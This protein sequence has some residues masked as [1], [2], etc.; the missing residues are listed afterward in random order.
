MHQEIADLENERVALEV[1]MKEYQQYLHVFSDIKH[2]G[3]TY[4]GGVCLRITRREV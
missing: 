3:V 1:E 2:I 4:G